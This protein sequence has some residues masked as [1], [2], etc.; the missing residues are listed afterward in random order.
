MH[1]MKQPELG[2]R[3][4]ERR[5]S[6]GITQEELASRC[7]F[8]VRTL[9]RIE[10]GSVVPRKYTLGLITEALGG[11][12]DGETPRFFGRVR[13]E[14]RELFNFKTY[15]MAKI[16]FLS[17]VLLATGLSIVLFST[18]ARAQTQAQTQN[19]TVETSEQLRGLI[20][21]G[22]PY[23]GVDPKPVGG[24]LIIHAA[25]TA[26]GVEDG[27]A[28]ITHRGDKFELVYGNL[29]YLN[30]IYFATLEK[31]DTVM[32]P[33]RRDE[34]WTVRK[35][36]PVEFVSRINGTIRYVAPQK[37]EESGDDRSGDG[38]LRVRYKFNN[39]LELREADG[40]LYVNG[41]RKFD[42]ADGDTVVVDKDWTVSI[43]KK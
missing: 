12:Q 8:T 38:K 7:G 16:S 31:G 17:S 2:K 34:K 9:Q 25:A 6:R 18:E 24:Y 4:A 35:H 37:P 5:R 10:A 28:S 3:I 32:M 33:W 14:L 22:A 21:G 30:D 43:R 27:S 39:G 19:P 36:S 26:E 15:K 42:L 29:A 20:V 11:V 23:F 41:E 40:G 13:D 1:T